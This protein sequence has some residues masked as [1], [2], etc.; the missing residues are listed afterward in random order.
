MLQPKTIGRVIAAVL[1]AAP[2]VYLLAAGKPGAGG[3]QAAEGALPLAAPLP[4]RTPPGVTLT[5]GDPMTQKVLEATGWERTLPFHIKWVRMTGGPAVTE[6]FH[7]K[8]LDV[9]AAAD[10]PPVHAVWVGIPVKIIA[11]AQRRDPIA[12]P[13]WVMAIGPKSGIATLGDLR[14]KRIAFSPGQVQGEVVLRTL[15][16]HG[17]TKSDV[18]L[19]EMPSTSADVYINA[20]VAGQID[21]A[22]IANG[23]AAHHYLASFGG[24]GARIL[25]HGAFRDDLVDLYV[26]TETLEDPAKAAALARYVEIWGRA[27]AWIERHPDEW[28]RLYYEK[29][30]GLAA[31]DARYVIKASGARVVP[32][33]WGPAVDQEQGAVDLLARETGQKPFLASSLFDRRFEPIAAKAFAAALAHP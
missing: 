19:V 3:G 21:A 20:L 7:A 5:I 14:G 2:V 24:E 11:V 9:G 25:R 15:A 10:I 26:R 30:Q 17:L 4:D 22:P 18:T 12:Y 1:L 27:Q 23:V 28:A 31:D 33:D 6:A 13:T 16:E 29:D 32:S 8:A